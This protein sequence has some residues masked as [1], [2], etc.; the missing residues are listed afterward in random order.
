[1][2]DMNGKIAHMTIGIWAMGL[3]LWIAASSAICDELAQD[4]EPEWEPIGRLGDMALKTERY[5]RFSMGDYYELQLIVH[6]EKKNKKQGKTIL[7]NGMS[8]ACSRVRIEKNEIAFD[9]PGNRYAS[10]Y[11]KTTFFYRWDAAK[12]SF[13]ETRSEK[14]D[15]WADNMKLLKQY[16]KNGNFHG[17]AAQ[18]VRMGTTPNG[19]HTYLNAEMAEMFFHAYHRRA[20]DLYRKG[21]KRQ[22]ADDALMILFAP[23]VGLF[24]ECNDVSDTLNWGL[25]RRN[26]GCFVISNTQSNISMFNDLA[27]YIEQHALS[28]NSRKALILADDALTFVVNAA[29][30]RP[31][32]L[33]NLADARWEIWKDVPAGKAVEFY[34]QYVGLMTL[35]GK[36]KLIPKR[37]LERAK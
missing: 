10:E 23:P 9:M 22:A 36:T 30:E 8:T 19:G 29:P 32:A 28:A 11:S 17:A 12:K 7:Y 2:A 4:A 14:I 31:A 27:F 20:T 37:A 18:V 13:I 35:A 33:L 6:W 25:W 26:E 16:L 3:G 1:M 34:R 24:E 5:C 15:P 21:K